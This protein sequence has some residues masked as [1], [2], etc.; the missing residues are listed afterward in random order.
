MNKSVLLI[1]GTRPEAIKMAPIFEYL[2]KNHSE[3]EL[4]VLA[5]GQHDQLL[6][7]GLVGFN[8]RIDLNLKLR[9]EKNNVASYFA[10]L[11][12]SVTTIL[13]S[14]RP[15]LVL[16]HGDTTTAAAAALAAHFCQIPVGHVEA[17]LRSNRLDAPWPE[18]ANRRV[19]DSISTLLFAPTQSAANQIVKDKN[20]SVIVTGNTVL[21]SLKETL[22]RLDNDSE[23]QSKLKLK[24][25]HL[26][27]N[28]ILVTQHRRESF[29][30][31]HLR[32]LE[33]INRIASAHN[34]VLFPVHPNPNIKS[35]AKQIL[36]TNPN[37]YLVEPLEY[38]E[39][40]Y[41][42]RNARLVISDSGG[43]QEEAPS[44]GLPLI[45]TRE[46]TERAEISLA[47][48]NFLLGSDPQLIE[49]KCRE[50]LMTPRD[51]EHGRF[52]SSIY[53]DGEA[54]KKI[55]ESCLKFLSD[56]NQIIE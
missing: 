47:E 21:D 22:T 18:E 1:L 41:L 48:T 31:K 12:S 37:V 35:Q 38:P 3:I 20:S 9:N 4:K 25:S 15:D 52:R 11:M 28:Y 44:L 26:G 56:S 29:G 24:Y 46:V 32:I 55:V 5:S 6:Q 10:E 7:D 54:S 50:I 8:L 30:M 34:K 43:I 39:F 36:G 33:T 23:L 49:Q 45:I 2:T 14:H 13:N 42:M 40:V 19:I 17:G 27:S 51:H 53:G 16:V